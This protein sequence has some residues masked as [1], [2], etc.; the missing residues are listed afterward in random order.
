MLESDRQARRKQ[1]H[2][3]QIEGGAR[4][5]LP[6]AA[7]LGRM[8]DFIRLL[9]SSISEDRHLALS[10][11]ANLGQFEIVKLLLEAG[12][13][14]NRYNPVGGHSHTTP[15]LQAA[16]RGYENIVRL[17]VE[18]GARLDTKDLLWNATPADWARHSGMKE[19]EA[20]LL[21]HGARKA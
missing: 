8:A 1:R 5:N 12:V 19:I 4:I 18:H 11:A 3:A 10:V 17:L 20:Y 9:P 16:G 13:S 14:S 7:G 6:I 21:A 2:P 15:L